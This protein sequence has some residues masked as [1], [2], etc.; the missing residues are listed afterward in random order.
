MS[1]VQDGSNSAAVAN[2]TTIAVTLAGVTAGNLIRV[3]AACF[4]SGGASRTITVSDGTNS[5]T[6]ALTFYD[7][8]NSGVNMAELYLPN[9]PGGSTTLTATFS[10]GT[11]TQFIYAQERSN[12]ATSSALNV[13]GTANSTV[14]GASGA[15]AVVANA[16]TTT[17]G[18][19]T[20]VCAFAVDVSGAL[21]INAGT[22][23][24]WAD[25]SAHKWAAQGTQLSMDSE[26]LNAQV[27]ASYTATFG[28]ST[29]GDRF[30]AFATAYNNPATGDTLM[31]MQMN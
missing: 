19:T 10:A 21:T 1:F 3:V 31:P 13:A 15:N 26:D 24:T 2:A 30:T 25:R 11:T 7:G 9:V 18:G 8:A 5:Y 20:D 12:I 29:S 6:S 23:L 28:I 4:A 16:I 17:G 22:T 14:P 27:A